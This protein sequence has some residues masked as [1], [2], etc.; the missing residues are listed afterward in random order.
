MAIGWA[1]PGL[2]HH[3]TPPVA[4]HIHRLHLRPR[5]KNIGERT[6]PA[7]IRGV[8]LQGEN[9]YLATSRRERDRR[10]TAMRL[11]TLLLTV[12][13]CPLTAQ[14]GGISAYEFLNLPNSATVAA[15]G[16]HHMA[17]R[18]DDLSLALRNPALLNREM[19]GT[20]ALSHAFHLADISNSSL[21]YGLY[22]EDWKMTFQGALQYVSYGSDLVRRD[23]TGQAQGTFSASDFA[24]TL[25]AGRTFENR[26]SVGANLKVVSSQLGGFNSMGLA[27]DLAVHYQDTSGRWGLSLLARNAG[28]Q[29]T[30]YDGEGEPL[31]F[32]L[33]I[34]YTKELRYLPFRFSVIYRYLDRWNILYD[35]PNA[36]D[37]SLTTLFGDD[38]EARS[39][40]ALFFDNLA[41]HFV[42]NGELMIGK[43]RNFRLRF[44]YNHG[45]RRELRLTEF[46]SFAGYSFGFAFRTKRFAL[47][48]GRGTYHLAGGVNQLGVDVRLGSR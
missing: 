42:F 21:A 8:G 46:R 1:L 40:G 17:L 36:T 39:A 33:Q 35:D 18:D 26:L 23:N 14:I 15:M 30:R 7:G 44:G 31:P 20:V 47:S 12:F 29:L 48:Y 27:A 10:F 2:N 28:A 41:R 22:R 38:P 45:M 4:G 34:G 37:Q 5:P 9:A 16:G 19:S 6:T 32:E 24:L 11:L 13:C 3:C 43:Q 25:G